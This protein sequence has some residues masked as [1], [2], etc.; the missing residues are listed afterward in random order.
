MFHKILLASLLGLCAAN[1]SLSYNAQ[2]LLQKENEQFL[3]CLTYTFESEEFCAQMLIDQL[4]QDLM[5][6]TIE[7]E[8]L[9]ADKVTATYKIIDHGHNVSARFQ[10]LEIV[11]DFVVAFFARTDLIS[12][13]ILL[14]AIQKAAQQNRP[15]A[16]TADY[17]ECIAQEISTI[18]AT[19]L[20]STH[21]VSHLIQQYA[22]T[23][24]SWH[25]LQT[26]FLKEGAIEPFVSSFMKI[27]TQLWLGH[28]TKKLMV[29]WDPWSKDRS[30]R[31]IPTDLLSHTYFYALLAYDKSFIKS[32]LQLVEK[33][34]RKSSTHRRALWMLLDK[35]I[36]WSSSSLGSALASALGLETVARKELFKIF[37]NH[38]SSG[39]MIEIHWPGALILGSIPVFIASIWF[40][41]PYIG[42]QPVYSVALSIPYALGVTSALMYLDA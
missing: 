1:Q 41:M 2:V 22:L 39:H 3:H 30:V 25:R 20:L 35:E 17:L 34:C 37:K 7:L 4:K 24:G 11:Q 15:T 14:H 29:E 8:S 10:A 9:G 40:A 13:H 18:D 16:T 19:A 23:S 32:T 36:R 38:I 21:A 31:T 27:F 6:D 12:H 28:L 33:A 42:D 5:V 26:V